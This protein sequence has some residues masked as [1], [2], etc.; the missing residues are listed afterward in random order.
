MSN[1][2]LRLPDSLH[3]YAKKMAQE[4]HASRLSIFRQKPHASPPNCC[5]RALKDRAAGCGTYAA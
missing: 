5:D 3:A 1:F 2:A 4:D